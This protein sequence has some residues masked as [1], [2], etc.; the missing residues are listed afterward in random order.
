MTLQ[1][2]VMV[3]VIYAILRT[4]QTVNVVLLAVVA[5]GLIQIAAV[6]L[7]QTDMSAALEADRQ[8]GLTDQRQQFGFSHD[9]LCAVWP[10]VLAGSRTL[11]QSNACRHTG[12]HP[13]CRFCSLEQW[14]PQILTCAGVC[15]FELGSV[16]HLP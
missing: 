6:W 5:G 9:L 10:D 2:L 12:A 15:P 16:L 3:W 1:I 7:G 11:A 4:R 14:F 8:M 13:G